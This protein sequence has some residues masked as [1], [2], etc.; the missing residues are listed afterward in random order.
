M[1]FFTVFFIFGTTGSKNYINTFSFNFERQK[2]S[3]GG[4]GVY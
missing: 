4:G 3:D 2:E 1:I